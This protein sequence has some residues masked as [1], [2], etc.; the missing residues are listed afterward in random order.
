MSTAQVTNEP[1]QQPYPMDETARAAMVARYASHRVAIDG[2]AGELGVSVAT[3]IAWA[4]TLG[5]RSTKPSKPK[6][7]RFGNLQLHLMR[8]PGGE[9]AGDKNDDR[10]EAHP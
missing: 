4:V 8:R 1:H 10:D 2:L 6:N 5:L 7:H 9:P 3:I